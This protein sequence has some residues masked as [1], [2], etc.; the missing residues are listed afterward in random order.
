[1]MSMETQ[2]PT[3]LASPLCSSVAGEAARGQMERI[4]LDHLPPKKSAL[5]LYKALQIVT[6]QERLFPGGG[7]DQECAICYEPL[8]LRHNLSITPCGHYFCF[9]CITTS[10]YKLS[11]CPCCRKPLMPTPATKRIVSTPPFRPNHRLV[12]DEE[13]E[14]DEHGDW[15]N[16]EL[17]EGEIAER[18]RAD[19]Y[20]GMTHDGYVAEWTRADHYMGMTHDGY[21]EPGN[22]PV[23][24]HRVENDP[25]DALTQIMDDLNVSELFPF[26]TSEPSISFTAFSRS[27]TPSSEDTR[28]D[29]SDV[30]H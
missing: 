3:F 24:H 19:H 20:M 27:V 16:H 4:P 10:M 23:V 8:T 15:D 9:Q 2:R 28:D 13:E 12:F 1:M 7:M 22:L 26:Y 6:Q 29:I 18:T 21:D 11:T 14:E 25:A 5:L 30:T 17:E